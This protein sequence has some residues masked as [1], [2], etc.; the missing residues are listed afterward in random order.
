MN[1]FDAAVLSFL[2]QFAQQSWSFDKFVVVFSEVN[3]IK[4]AAVVALLWWL[5]F[6]QSPNQDKTRTL[7][8]TTCLA[9]PIAL[10]LSKSAGMILPFRSRPIYVEELSLV[11]PHT[12]RAGAIE[13]WSSFPS[14]HAVFF[15]ALATGIFFISKRV[16]WLA[17]F[18]VLLVICFPRLYINY[19]YPTD[20]IA[21][22]LLGSV[23]AFLV[24]SA[25]PIKKFMK[26]KGLGWC[27]RHPAS[28]YA[29]FF[30]VSYQI[31]NLFWES[32][33]ILKWAVYMAR[34]VVE[35]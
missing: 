6:Q 25:S 3:L 18:Y 5:W 7:I 33:Q 35:K 24:L 11:L 13:T 27:Q 4:G 14:D 2:N 28:F 8:L 23:V 29:F 30:L 21:G 34:L 16:G 32:R 10:F 15:F 19:H 9:C 31:A 17:F 20:V 22:A 12:M 26:E 1:G